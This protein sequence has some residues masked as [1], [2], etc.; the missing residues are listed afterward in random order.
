VKVKSEEH[1]QVDLYRNRSRLKWVVLVIAALISIASVIYTNYLVEKIREREERIITLYA[2]TL[3]HFANDENNSNLTFVFDAI[4]VANNTIPV[5]VADELGRPI[6]FKNIPDAEKAE[7]EKLK[8]RILRKELDEMA[9]EH[10]PLLITFR[11]ELNEIISYQY[12]YYKNSFL[13]TQLQYYPIGQLSVIGIF[14]ILA[15][16]AFRYSKTA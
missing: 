7:S 5:I 3:E 8:Q 12:I 10:E 4:I 16:L 14:A 15:F 13:L 11:N 2:S 6:D 9:S 1:L